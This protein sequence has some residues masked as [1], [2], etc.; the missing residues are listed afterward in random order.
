MRHQKKGKKLD[1]KKQPRELMLRNL[2]SSL[3]IYEKI[4]T[5][6]AKAKA[7]KPLVEKLI[8]TAAKGDLTTRRKLIKVLPQPM[9]VK[10]ALEILGARYRERPGGYT[11]IIKLGS[12]QGDGAKIVQIELV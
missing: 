10:K 1:R 5:T 6:E 11:R 2:A 9:A 3:I 12:R 4:K 8:T 7:V